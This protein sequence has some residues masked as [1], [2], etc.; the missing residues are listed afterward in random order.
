MKNIILGILLVSVLVLVGCSSQTVVKYQCIDGSFVDSVDSCPK[1][2]TQTNCPELDC[3]ACGVDVP[4]KEIIK[5][6][7]ADGTIKEKVSDC[8]TVSIETQT[9]NTV[10]P[11]LLITINSASDTTQYLHNPTITITNE[12]SAV[13]NLVYDVE[14]YKSSRLVASDTDIIYKSGRISIRSID[15]GDS[16]KGYLNVMIY[17]GNTAGFTTGTHT[18][19]VIVR[20]GASAK[21][22]A[23]AEKEVTFS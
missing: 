21:P 19:K 12:G 2:N 4:A 5:Y 13:D 8:S 14:L 20:R 18:F 6:Q 10:E 23:T 1:S 9:Q 7:C 16:V 11:D 22:I 3:S 15:A 17:S